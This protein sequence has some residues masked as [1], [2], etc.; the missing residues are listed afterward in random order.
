MARMEMTRS[1]PHLIETLTAASTKYPVTSDGIR[2]SWHFGRISLIPQ[3]MND[4]C[5]L[6]INLPACCCR[7]RRSAVFPIAGRMILS[8]MSLLTAFNIDTFSLLIP[9]SIVTSGIAT[10][11][12]RADFRAPQQGTLSIGSDNNERAMY[13][14]DHPSGTF[15]PGLRHIEDARR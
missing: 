1:L 13:R 14:N 10:R 2:N 6:R 12:D 4:G 3:K 9:Y 8:S 15:T 7:L 5:G 11:Q